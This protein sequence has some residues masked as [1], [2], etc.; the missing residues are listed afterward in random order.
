MILIPDNNT[1]RSFIPNTMAPAMGETPLYDKILPFLVAAEN[2]LTQ[3]FIDRELLMQIVKDATDEEDPLYFLPR[4]IVVLKAWINALPSIDVLVS[5]HG[6]GVAETQTMKAASKFKIE[7]LR[8]AT[9]SELDYN[10]ESLVNVVWRIPGWLDTKQAD[11]FRQSLF[12]DFTILDDLGVKT[13][14]YSE[15]LIH[16][17]R[18]SL[19]ERRI[20]REWISVPLLSRFRA[21]SLAREAQG[22]VLEV[23]QLVRDA[24]IHEL[25]SGLEN[26]ENLEDVVN[27]IRS[28]KTTFAEWQTSDTANRF[29]GPNYRNRK[30]DKGFWL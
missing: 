17:K 27:L 16:A 2:W 11:I 10:I 12:P 4:R 22:S 8:K 28:D 6:V 20:A 14:R 26:R 15:Y 25:S 5:S 3:N 23:I 24:V 21:L 18:A 1:L 7:N 9:Q 29:K 19:I 30:E 13:D